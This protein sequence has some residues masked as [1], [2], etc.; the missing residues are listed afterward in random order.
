MQYTT[1]YNLNK[2]ELTD[3]ADITKMSDNMDIID[4]MLKSLTDKIYPV[5][6]IYMSVSSTDPATIF[7]GT[8]VQIANGK[9]LRTAGGNI[10]AEDTG[11]SDTVTLATA[12]LPSHTHTATSANAGAHTHAVS[13]TTSSAGAH[14]HTKGTMNIVGTITNNSGTDEEY[15]T[16]ADGITSTGALRVGKYG[17]TKGAVGSTTTGGAY[18]EI[19]FDASRTGAWTGSTSSAG[20]HTHTASGTAASAGSHKHTITVGSTGSGTA[21]SVVNAYYAVYMW[22]RTA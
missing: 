4:T 15:L 2:P 6:S 8:W 1:N 18:N 22:K 17:T 7:G 20:A 13:V 16:Y 14:T 9:M 5:G 21:F 11:G 19:S 3:V 10:A 12:N